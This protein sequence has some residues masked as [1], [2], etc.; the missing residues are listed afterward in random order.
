M[1]SSY[2]FAKIIC[3]ECHYIVFNITKRKV[4]ADGQLKYRY[5]LTLRFE[6]YKDI[7]NSDSY[8][9]CYDK[10]IF[11]HGHLQNLRLFD[12]K[13]ISLSD[14]SRWV[15]NPKMLNDFYYVLPQLKKKSRKRRR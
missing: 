8:D 10:E 14:D 13:K 6:S 7:I 1:V 11:Y 3:K 5:C 2:E 15:Q 9:L 4:E 12:S